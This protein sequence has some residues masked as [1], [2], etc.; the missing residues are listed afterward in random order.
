MVCSPPRHRCVT[1]CSRRGQ[2]AASHSG[3]LHTL[4]PLTAIHLPSLLHQRQSVHIDRSSSAELGL[5]QHA[6]SGFPAPPCEIDTSSD[7]YSRLTGPHSCRRRGAATLT[8]MHS[9]WRR[10]TSHCA[11]MRPVHHPSVL[12]CHSWS[13]RQSP[14]VLRH[15]Q[16]SFQYSS[17]AVC[18]SPLFASHSR[19]ILV[20][21]AHVAAITS[22]PR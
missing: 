20:S 19:L 10:C 21:G 3:M 2:H 13:T 6:A 22:P 17:A 18:P 16:G 14:T 11:G 4:W 9:S 8:S 5:S 1:L 7:P 12:H 15:W